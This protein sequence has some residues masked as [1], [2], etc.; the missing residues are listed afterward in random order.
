MAILHRQNSFTLQTSNSLRLLGNHFQ[1]KNI[2]GQSPLGSSNIFFGSLALW[3]FVSMAMQ[4]S[5]AIKHDL[6]LCMTDIT[7][8]SAPIGTQIPMN[9]VKDAGKLS[10]RKRLKSS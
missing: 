7:C 9:N 6:N 3:M 10:G 4:Q 2:L 1:K 5:F 8:L